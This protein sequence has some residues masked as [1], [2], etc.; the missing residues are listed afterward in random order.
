M[1]KP[2][3]RSL[4]WP[5]LMLFFPSKP[6]FLGCLLFQRDICLCPMSF[7]HQFLVWNN[8]QMHQDP[9]SSHYF[10]YFHTEDLRVT[11]AG[12][13]W[14]GPQPPAPSI[15][16]GLFG[17]ITEKY[18]MVVGESRILHPSDCY[19][20]KCLA[21]YRAWK[22]PFK[23]RFQSVVRIIF[24]SSQHLLDSLTNWKIPSRSPVIKFSWSMF[25]SSFWKQST[26]VPLALARKPKRSLRF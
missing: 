4:F 16:S 2:L 13:I 12:A 23:A 15:F 25:L 19:V 17:S 6:K 26:A 3:N 1:F 18:E 8:F 9:Y 14:I 10:I 7:P 21:Q 5:F 22:A 11:S 24:L 20:A